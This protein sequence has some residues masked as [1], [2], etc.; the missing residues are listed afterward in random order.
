LGLDP[1]GDLRVNNLNNLEDAIVEAIEGGKRGRTTF[2][3]RGRS[4]FEQ[5]IRRF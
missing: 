1:S 5:G 4:T 2:R 3:K